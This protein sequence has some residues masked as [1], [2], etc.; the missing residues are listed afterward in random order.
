MVDIKIESIAGLLNSHEFMMGL[1]V[2]AVI[3][4]FFWMYGAAWRCRYFY[5]SAKLETAVKLGREFFYIVPEAVYNRA[6]ILGAKR[7]IEL[8]RLE[9]LTDAVTKKTD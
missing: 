3:G 9:R 7:K 1:L 6:D 5:D 2:G 8:E 4:L